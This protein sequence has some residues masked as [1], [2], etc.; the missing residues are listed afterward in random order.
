[1]FQLNESKS[2]SLPTPSDKSNNIMKKKRIFVVVVVGVFLFFL[3]FF[4]SFF[5]LFSSSL[6]PETLSQNHKL[7]FHINIDTASRCFMEMESDDKNMMMMKLVY[8]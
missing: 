1:M 2:Y 8:K 6:L 7:H 3:S 5:L 4:F